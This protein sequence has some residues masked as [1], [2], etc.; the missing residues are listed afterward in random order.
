MSAIFLIVFRYFY[1]CSRFA[2]DYGGVKVTFWSLG[3]CLKRKSKLD[4]YVV[5]AFCYKLFKDLNPSESKK[6]FFFHNM[7]VSYHFFFVSSFLFISSFDFLPVR[8][9][10]DVSC[11]LYC[12]FRNFSYKS[13]IIKRERKI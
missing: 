12:L 11:L 7:S 3:Q 8:F 10:C 4:N 6:H 9:Y 1:F 13:G 2:I 5:N